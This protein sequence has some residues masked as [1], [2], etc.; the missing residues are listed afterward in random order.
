[1]AFELIWMFVIVVT[2]TV[3][4]IYVYKQI[5]HH[6]CD[7]GYQL[8]INYSTPTA[9]AEA[10]LQNQKCTGFQ[11]MWSGY[12]YS[13][14]CYCCTMPIIIGSENENWDI[15]AY[16]SPYVESELIELFLALTWNVSSP[17][18]SLY[19]L[20]INKQTK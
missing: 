6:G 16:T 4:S 12:S 14:G 18:Y 20:M 15:Y 8:G 11:L 1:M 19:S 17:T 13:W 3:H 10:A 7:S 2:E 9:C 5:E